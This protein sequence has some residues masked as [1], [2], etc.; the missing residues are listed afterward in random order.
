MDLV[1]VM[2]EVS[3]IKGSI[4]STGVIFAIICVIA[5]AVLPKVGAKCSQPVT[6]RWGETFLLLPGLQIL[7][8]ISQQMRAA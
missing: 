6:D 1:I 2:P 8:E 3:T 7:R 4:G 5:A